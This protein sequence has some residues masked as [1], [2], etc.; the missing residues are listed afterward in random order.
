MPDSACP[1]EGK[2]LYAWEMGDPPSYIPED[3]GFKVGDDF[4]FVVIQIHYAHE[5]KMRSSYPYHVSVTI[6]FSD[7]KYCFI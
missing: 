1:G 7:N 2:L 6:D 3:V 5:M 4:P